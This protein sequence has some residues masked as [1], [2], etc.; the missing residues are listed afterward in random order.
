MRLKNCSFPLCIPNL[1]R[2]KHFQFTI[3]SPPQQSA[4][5]LCCWPDHKAM[6]KYIFIQFIRMNPTLSQL[7]WF[8]PCML[9]ELTMCYLNYVVPHLK[10]CMW[11]WIGARQVRAS[12]EKKPATLGNF[13]SPTTFSLPWNPK[14][15]ISSIRPKWKEWESSL[16]GPCSLPRSNKTTPQSVTCWLKEASPPSI[17]L[18]SSVS[19]KGKCFVD[20]VLLINEAMLWLWWR[21]DGERHPKPGAGKD[22]DATVCWWHDKKGPK[23]HQV[24]VASDHHLQCSHRWEAAKLQFW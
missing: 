20:S 11:R 16:Q 15:G 17:I 24:T 18:C 8:S 14:E 21:K 22:T 13:F 7:L 12:V 3:I 19:G 6:D 5:T 10:S 9:V 4:P 1:Q 23:G 2:L